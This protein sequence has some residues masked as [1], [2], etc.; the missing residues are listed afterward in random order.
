MMR[1]VFRI[2]ADSMNHFIMKNL[3]KVIL[4]TLTGLLLFASMFQ[5]ATHAWDFKKLNGVEV[6]IPQPSLTFQNCR[7]GSFQE[8]TEG[9]L[10]Q[11]FGFR[12]PLVR[13]YNQYLW[14]CYQKT[15]VGAG[16]L[17]FGK[18]G[19]LY[20]P[21]VVA[22]Y[23]QIQ[24][25]NYAYDSAQMASMLTEEAHRVLQLQQ[26]L[27]P[28]GT[29]L[30]VCQVPAKDL[31]CPEHLPE[32]Q[33]KRFDDEPKI[34]ARFF[35]E[36]KYTQLGVNHLNLEQWFLQMK[37]TADFPLFPKTGTH[38]SYYASLFAA[39]TLIRYMEHLGDINMKNIVIGPRT[40]DK[41]NNSDDDLESLLNLIRPL[42]NSQYYYANVSIEEDTAAVMP[43]LITVGDS[44]WWNISN[45][46]PMNSIFSSSP[47]WYYNSTIYFDDNYSSVNEVNLAEQLLS[48]DFIMLFYSATQQYKL[49]NDFTKDAMIALC[50]DPEEIA[51]VRTTLEQLIRSDSSWMEKLKD[52]AASQ[53]KT[54][55]E[56]VNNEVKWLINNNLGKYFPALNDSLPTKRSRCVDAYFNVDSLT[57]IEQEVEKVIQQI[58]GDEKQMEDINQKALKYGKTLE[59]ALYDDALWVVNY[60][61]EQGILQIPS[62]SRKKLMSWEESK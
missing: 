38:W 25:R 35:N 49:N 6:P 17:T 34:S 54:L 3:V 52:K 45:Q 23:Y 57:F 18:D 55:D 27:E 42:P 32:N 11:N 56:T 53:Y 31:I 20:E 24:F 43:K 47:Y 61:L 37:D 8:R 41:A 22:D 44:F 39:D 46:I 9:Y 28:Y 30:F 5:K 33:D 10:K 2:F 4:F 51:S 12:E 48:A 1:I 60:K 58:K 15:P 62:R 36:E 50:Y 59:Q 7:D 14:D 29:R 26:L 21:W 16:I 19:W 13:L 40:L